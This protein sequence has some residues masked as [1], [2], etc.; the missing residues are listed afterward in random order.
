MLEQTN[1]YFALESNKHTYCH[2]TRKPLDNFL[3]YMKVDL[4][5][6]K[7]SHASCFSR[8]EAVDYRHY[9]YETQ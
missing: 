7:C 9:C 5:A 4:L 2:V 3:T 1:V 6:V 8:K